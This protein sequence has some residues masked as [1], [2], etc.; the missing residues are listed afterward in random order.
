MHLLQR[1][2]DVKIVF[3]IVSTYEINMHHQHDM[4]IFTF[5]LEWIDMLKLIYFSLIPPSVRI[6][7]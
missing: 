1:K 5:S 3:K 4:T 7:I 2:F 6:C